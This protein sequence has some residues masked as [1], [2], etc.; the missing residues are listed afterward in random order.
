MLADA[1]FSILALAISRAKR[2]WAGSRA[3]IQEAYKSVV[4][5]H[6]D[7]QPVSDEQLLQVLSFTS[8]S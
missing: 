4:G 3:N 8:L 7:R 2:L 1:I 5:W 6:L